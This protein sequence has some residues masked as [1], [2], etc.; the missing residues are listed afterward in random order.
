LRGEGIGDFHIAILQN[1]LPLRRGFIGQEVVFSP[2]GIPS[3]DKT[4]DG[5]GVHI[6]GVW[7][8]IAK[9]NSLKSQDMGPASLC[10]D[11]SRIKDE[12]AIIIQ[13]GDEVPLF[14]GGGCPEMMRG[15]MLNEF[16]DITG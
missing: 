15:V 7:E 6:V 1:L 10:S 8:S 5:M 13:G 14:L 4:E 11:Q 3:L 16:S 12:A 2:K 9:D